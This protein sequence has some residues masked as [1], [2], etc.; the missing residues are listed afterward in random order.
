M[1]S[2]D[3]VFAIVGA[4]LVIDAFMWY[5]AVVNAY[6]YQQYWGILLAFNVILVSLVMLVILRHYIKGSEMYG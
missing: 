2:S 4:Q 6:L 1:K 3:V 5:F